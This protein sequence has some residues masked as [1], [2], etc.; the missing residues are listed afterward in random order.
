MLAANF[1]TRPQIYANS[2][3]MN[4]LCKTGSMADTKKKAKESRELVKRECRD[5]LHV[6]G[7]GLF[8]PTAG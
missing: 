2:Y 3:S 7:V 4:W 1:V 6:C 8:S 5:S